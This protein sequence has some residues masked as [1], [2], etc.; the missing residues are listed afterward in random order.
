MTMAVFVAVAVACQSVEREG[1]NP[2][3]KS[4]AHFD[5]AG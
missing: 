5:F 3:A 4:G 2:D 1:E